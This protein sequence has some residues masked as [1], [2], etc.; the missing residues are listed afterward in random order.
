MNFDD[1]DSFLQF[2]NNTASDKY[3]IQLPFALNRKLFVTVVFASDDRARS[4]YNISMQVFEFT[5]REKYEASMKDKVV[6]AGFSTKED[7][8]K[9][10]KFIKDLS[11]AHIIGGCNQ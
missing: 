8:K 2:L 3:I 11:E 1:I 7:L 6:N 10:L 4:K 5:S 9:Y